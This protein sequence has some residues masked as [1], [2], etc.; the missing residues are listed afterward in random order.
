MILDYTVFPGGQSAETKPDPCSYVVLCVRTQRWGNCPD[1]IR[2]GCAL[3]VETKAIRR[4]DGG[5]DDESWQGI[6]G[7][8][9][10]RLFD[11][12]VEGGKPGKTV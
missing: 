5:D 8:S 3:P 9:K 11:E 10:N 6:Y 1:R 4:G 2:P 7:R 12:S